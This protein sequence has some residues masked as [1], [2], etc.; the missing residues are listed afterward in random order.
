WPPGGGAGGGAALVGQGGRKGP[1]GRRG[2]EGLWGIIFQGDGHGADGS[3]EDSRKK[4]EDLVVLALLT[5]RNFKMDTVC[6]LP[7]ARDRLV[8]YLSN[9]FPNVRKQAALTCCQ[10]LVE[11]GRPLFLKGPSA[12][13]TEELLE[14]LLHMAVSEPIA[15]IRQTLLHALDSRFD[16]FLCQAHHLQTLFLLMGDD[17]FN[18]RL[19]SL[20]MLG[21]LAQYNPSYLLPPLR[22]TLMQIL[23]ELRYNPDVTAGEEATKM[24]C[25]FLRA[26]ALQGLLYPFIEAILLALPLKGNAR[27]AT[28]ALEALGELCVGAS[29]LMLPYMD[30]L[31]PFI[32]KC[33][34]DQSSALK[35]E[36]SLRTLGRLISS[37]RCVIKP[38]IRYPKLMDG[39]LAVLVVGGGVNSPW[40]L[41]RE[42]LRT[43]GIMGAL[44]PYKYNKIQLFLRAQKLS[45]ESVA[46][47]APDD[48]SGA[49]SNG[50][51]EVGSGAGA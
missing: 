13:V 36:V 40:S 4:K 8:G 19:D 50:G 39:V 17:D 9:E 7:F 14:R 42:T 32:M 15:S 22:Q 37:T 48:V 49:G 26:P 20:T 12:Q 18:I 25:K 31:I 38:Y 43:L 1:D 30:D 21:R 41:R 44:D 33:M 10:L 46:K 45:D 3:E 24:L 28:T 5:L 27:L 11:P 29:G 23:V 51:G 6:L 16:A 47:P 2:R 35:R 34:Q